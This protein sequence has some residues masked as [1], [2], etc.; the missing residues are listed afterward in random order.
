MSR[1]D[2]DARVRDLEERLRLL[3]NRFT[4]L[5]RGGETMNSGRVSVTVCGWLLAASATAMACDV[6]AYFSPYDP[7]EDMLVAQVALANKSIHCSLY[8][9]S[10]ARLAGVLIEAK[11]KGVEVGVGLDKLQASGPSDQHALLELAGVRVVIKKTSYL[12]HNKFCVIDGTT[13]LVG[14]Y[15]WSV[16]AQTQDNSLVVLSDCLRAPAAFEAAYRRIMARDAAP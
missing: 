13:V 8:G 6:A 11:T 3:D 12:E 7:V 2:D 9:I 1:Q 14:S 4:G 10:S 16:N 5:D 15:N